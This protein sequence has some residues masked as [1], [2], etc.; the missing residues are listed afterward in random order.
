MAIIDPRLSG[1]ERAEATPLWRR[2]AW[3]AAIWAMSVA[4][5][6]A[7]AMVIKAWLKG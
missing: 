2:L 5:L 1:A 7:V 3:M 6:G 4:V